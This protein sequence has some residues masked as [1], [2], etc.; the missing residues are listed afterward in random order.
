MTESKKIPQINGM[1]FLGTLLVILGHSHTSD[2]S[3]F[4]GTFF[5]SLIVFIYHFHMPAFFFVA[6]FLF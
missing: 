6:G 1:Y 5:E 2:W 3:A 4:S